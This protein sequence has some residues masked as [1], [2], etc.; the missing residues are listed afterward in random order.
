M[1]DWMLTEST[2]SKDVLPAFWRPIMVTSISVA[3]CMMS[4]LGRGCE[5]CGQAMGS[6]TTYQKVLSNQSYTFRNRPAISCAQPKLDK[7]Q[8]GREEDLLVSL[9]GAMPGF[10]VR[11]ARWCR[12]DGEAQSQVG[13]LLGWHVKYLN[14]ESFFVLLECRVN[15]NEMSRMTL[16]S[17]PVKKQSRDKRRCAPPRSRREISGWSRGR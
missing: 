2:R 16:L 7:P 8:S 17:A 12:R 1:G 13:S 6:S 9:E 14:S 5:L 10:D 3:L 4:V 11:D 15:R